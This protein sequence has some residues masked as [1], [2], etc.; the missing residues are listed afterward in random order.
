MRI[1]LNQKIYQLQRHWHNRQEVYSCQNN[2][3]TKPISKRTRIRNEKSVQFTDRERS[4]SI[5]SSWSGSVVNNYG[6]IQVGRIKRN[7][8]FW[9]MRLNQIVS[10]WTDSSCEPPCCV[11]I[12]ARSDWG[13]MTLI[14]FATEPI[15][16]YSFSRTNSRHASTIKRLLR[17][18]RRSVLIGL[19]WVSIQFSCFCLILDKT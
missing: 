13:Y 11:F 5:R 4:T 9:L 19:S 17:T 6:Q 1:L 12:P 8:R 3:K 10:Q 18:A 7:G 15:F 16:L 2:E 14:F